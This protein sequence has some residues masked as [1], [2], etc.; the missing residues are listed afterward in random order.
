MLLRALRGRAR[1]LLI[2]CANLANL[3]LARALRRR[4]ELAVRAALGAGRE[5]LVRQLLTESLAAGVGGGPLG[6]ALAA[7]R[8]AA[9]RA[10]WCPDSA[11]RGD[12]DVD[13][14]VL[15]AAALAVLTAPGFGVVPALRACGGI[16]STGCAKARAAASAARRERLRAALVVAEVAA[17]VVLLVCVGPARA[18]AVAL[19]KATRVPA[20]GRA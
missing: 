4:R 11:G 2:A 17:S 1:V 18:R 15:L 20:R 8:G 9:A 6:V 5:R 14:R 10:A 13:L 19:Q 3:L 16:D 12:A 7:A